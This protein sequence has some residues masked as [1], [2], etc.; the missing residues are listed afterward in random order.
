LRKKKRPA[1]NRSVGEK[2][3]AWMLFVGLALVALLAGIVATSCGGGATGKE[4]AEDPAE[5]DPQAGADLEHPSLGDEN[6][7][8]VM[9]EYAD[10][11]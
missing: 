7:P 8:V 5:D 10:Y 6:A 9:T 1:V 4:R 2:K 3:P 11:Q